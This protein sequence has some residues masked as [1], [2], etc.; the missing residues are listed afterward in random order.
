MIIYPKTTSSEDNEKSFIN[1]ETFFG[2]PFEV[3]FCKK[4]VISNQRPNSE[5]EFKHNKYTKKKN[6][7]I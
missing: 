7:F 3:K 2:L 6:Y 5:I 1:K 4:C